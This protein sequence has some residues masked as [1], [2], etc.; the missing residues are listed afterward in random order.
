M[1]EQI[2]PFDEW[3]KDFFQHFDAHMLSQKIAK[4][5]EKQR[6]SREKGKSLTL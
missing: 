4:L 3:L 1:Y 6:K 2:M 5:Q